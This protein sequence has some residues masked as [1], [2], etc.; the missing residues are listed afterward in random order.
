M[1]L[2]KVWV[3]EKGQG[4]WLLGRIGENWRQRVQLGEGKNQVKSLGV[5]W[6]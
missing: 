3:E 1:Y 6:T 2:T 5:G 4:G